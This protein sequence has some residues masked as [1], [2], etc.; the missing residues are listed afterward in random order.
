M[1]RGS[2]EYAVYVTGGSGL[3]QS[4][5]TGERSIAEGT[6]IIVLKESG[7]ILAAGEGGLEIFAVAIDV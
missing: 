3:I 1:E 6:G 7:A 2:V 5:A 4:A